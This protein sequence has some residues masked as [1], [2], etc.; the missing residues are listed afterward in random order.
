MKTCR[1]VE[2]DLHLF[3]TSATDGSK[4]SVSRFPL[5]TH[6]YPL[7]WVIV[8]HQDQ[9]GRCGE[10]RNPCWEMNPFPISTELAKRTKRHCE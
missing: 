2:V 6:R 3:F 9:C 4:W 8:G 1:G 7:D 10:M 5:F